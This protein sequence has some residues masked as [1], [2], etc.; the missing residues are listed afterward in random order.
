MYR[1]KII[2]SIQLQYFNQTII[3]YAEWQIREQIFAQ[4]ETIVKSV[5]TTEFFF[6]IKL[7][8]KKEVRIFT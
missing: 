7:Q 3:F 2:E 6:S 5:I 1:V 8:V 4:K